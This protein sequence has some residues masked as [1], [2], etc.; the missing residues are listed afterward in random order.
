MGSVGA[1]GFFRKIGKFGKGV[2]HTIAKSPYLKAGVA[3]L[4]VVFPP[5]GAA[6]AAVIGAAMAADKVIAAAE[7]GNADAKKL[8]KNTKALAKVG[9]KTAHRAAQILEKRAVA[10]KALPPH[11][12][13]KVV[14]TPQKL[15]KSGVVSTHGPMP[16]ILVLASGHQL[17]GRFQKVS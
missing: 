13:G 12:R 4:S 2:V 1:W 10:R 6:G 16:G 3:G 5:A 14:F 7:R 15:R 9:D 11:Q 8:I 17:R